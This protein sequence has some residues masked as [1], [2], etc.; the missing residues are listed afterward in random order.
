MN[1]KLEKQ[2]NFRK[3]QIS[4]KANDKEDT[5]VLIKKLGKSLI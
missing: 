1:D 4:P 5:F 2:E 3:N